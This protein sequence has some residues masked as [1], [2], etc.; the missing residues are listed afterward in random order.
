MPKSR[1][2]ISRIEANS[3]IRSLCCNYC[4][5]LRRQIAE[6]RILCKWHDYY[7]MTMM[8]TRVFLASFSTEITSKNYLHSTPM[9][10]SYTWHNIPLLFDRCLDS[11]LK[12]ISIKPNNEKCLP[13]LFQVVKHSYCLHLDT[14]TFHDR[15]YLPSNVS[16]H[17]ACISYIF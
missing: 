15:I 17:N 2:T 3:L 4:F 5:F 12:S 10:V 11:F 1:H 9:S 7:A 13:R 16:T 6:W 14:N 8:A